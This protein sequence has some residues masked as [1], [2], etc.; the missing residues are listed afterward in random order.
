VLVDV[1]EGWQQHMLTKW[2]PFNLAM[3]LSVAG[4]ST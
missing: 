3:F 4:E 2:P 1:G